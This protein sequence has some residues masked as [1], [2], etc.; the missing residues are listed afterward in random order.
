MYKSV[1]T[2]SLLKIANQFAGFDVVAID[3]GQFFAEITEFC[4]SLANAGK[5]VIVAA[6]DATF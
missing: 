6:L 3:E 5:I 4:E 1:K 2:D